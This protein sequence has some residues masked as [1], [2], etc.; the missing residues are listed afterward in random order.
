MKNSKSASY[1][2]NI[3]HLRNELHLLI[4]S[5]NLTST[6]VQKRSRE[7]DELILLYYKQTKKSH[8]LKEP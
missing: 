2:S 6:I 1:K 4:E 5:E 7:L 3:N 8:E